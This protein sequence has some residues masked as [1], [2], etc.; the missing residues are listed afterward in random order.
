M[1]TAAEIA[2]ALGGRAGWRGAGNYEAPCP[3][4]GHGK[5]RGDL[6]CSLS[7]RDGDKGLLVKCHA[8]CD[9]RDILDELKRRGLLNGA[10]APASPTA[11]PQR[12]LAEYARELWHQAQPIE[13]TLAER[14]LL[15]HRCIEITLPPSLRFHPR[16]KVPR[17]QLWFP[18]LVAAVSGA[19]HKI[20]AVQVLWLDPSTAA[21]AAIKP[22]RRTYGA[23]DRGAV[24]LGAC[25]DT[26]GLAEGIET[27]L[28]AQQ[29]TGV[30]TW[31]TLGAARL[32]R[33][34]IPRGVEWVHI[35]GDEDKAGYA[36]AK[37]AAARLSRRLLV[38][39]RWP[40]HAHKDW[41]DALRAKMGGA[42]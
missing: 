17:E 32:D 20:L 31:A 9:S 6:N 2:K 26:L 37:A 10:A 40:P 15:A 28:S 12:D 38:R 41:N 11:K 39:L 24:R 1:S 16:I 35:F 23:L 22:Q 18:A 33:V 3:C 7:I 5:G 27:A 29:L 25:S 19:D 14:Y 21:K 13:G 42:A 4:R 8:G 30:V 34:Q 36:K